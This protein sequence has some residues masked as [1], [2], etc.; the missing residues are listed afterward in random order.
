MENPL[1]FLHVACMGLWRTIVKNLV[2]CLAESGLMKIAHF[3]IG[4]LGSPKDVKLCKESCALLGPL[5]VFQAADDLS[6][7]EHFTL[8]WL[9]EIV[10]A[11]PV[12]QVRPV[13][14]LH[15]KAVSRTK[16]CEIHFH[17]WRDYM[18]HCL[19][20][21]WQEALEVMQD[22]KSLA[23]SVNYRGGPKP[24][25]SGNLWWSHSKHLRSLPSSRQVK[26]CLK[27][28][29]AYIA[30]EVWVL[31]NTPLERV[32][33]LHQP[34]HLIRCHGIPETYKDQA[35]EAKVVSDL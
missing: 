32:I 17:T 33:T 11:L 5:T 10:Q 22:T 13:L 7:Y 19:V 24:H 29:F 8:E 28:R 9:Q 34:K 25:F 3:H 26:K 27:T 1:I 23:V 14:Y 15:T 31:W 2:K 35:F 30:P 6:L 20:S 12:E 18:V 4:I 21:R 16:P